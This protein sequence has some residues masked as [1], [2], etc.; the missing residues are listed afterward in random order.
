MDYFSTEEM[1][2]PVLEALERNGGKVHSNR[3]LA[4]L[5]QVSE[6]EATKRVK[7]LGD[8]LYIVRKGKDKLISVRGKN[9]FLGH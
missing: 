9:W 2:N 7:E 3:E 5:M 8:R 1:S 4:A 6:G